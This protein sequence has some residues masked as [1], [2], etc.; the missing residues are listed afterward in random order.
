VNPGLCTVKNCRAY[1]NSGRKLTK[2]RS[3]FVGNLRV[4]KMRNEWNGGNVVRN[5]Q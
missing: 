2:L 3:D 1:L 4:S 5:G